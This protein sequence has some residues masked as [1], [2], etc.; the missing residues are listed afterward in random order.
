MKSGVL[1][2]LRNRRRLN[3]VNKK[4]KQEQKVVLEDKSLDEFEEINNKLHFSYILDQTKPEVDKFERAKIISKYMEKHSI[5]FTELASRLNI[6]KSTL[7][8]WLKWKD[9]K[10]DEYVSLREMG[11]S[12]SDVTNMLKSPNKVDKKPLAIVSLEKTL[13]WCKSI[14]G[15]KLDAETIQL[16]R[17]IRNELNGII[18]RAEKK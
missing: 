17:E 2:V 10:E 3:L 9:L 8:G 5:T 1:F 4:T 7:S 15:R 18:Y 12:E 11:M 16:I 13:R 14:N 6:G